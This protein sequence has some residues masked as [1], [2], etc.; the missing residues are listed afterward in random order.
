MI[1][2]AVVGM[3]VC[4]L[5]FVIAG[6]LRPMRQCSGRCGDCHETCELKDQEIR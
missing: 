6:V 3:A 1:R 4:A 2:D 5:L